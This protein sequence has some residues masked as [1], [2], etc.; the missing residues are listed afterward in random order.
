MK[1][2]YS[3]KKNRQKE[4]PKFKSEIVAV[5]TETKIKIAEYINFCFGL[6][7]LNTKEDRTSKIKQMRTFNKS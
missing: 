7:P 3:G 2:L 1:I 5:N 4:S 6:F